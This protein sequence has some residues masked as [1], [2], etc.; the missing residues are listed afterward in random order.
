LTL[1]ERG[2][3]VGKKEAVGQRIKT[4]RLSRGMTQADLAKAINQSQSSIT[5]YENGRREPDFETLEA[6]AD[7]FNVPLGSIVE[8]SPSAVPSGNDYQTEDLRLL[9]SDLSKLTPAQQK[10]ALRI[11]RA[12]FM[13]TN[14]ELFTEGDDD[15]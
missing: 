11:F 14:P 1:N 7:V 6:L 10:Q 8:D 5:M 15:K 12:T 9:V 3:F 13:I 4:M 2:D